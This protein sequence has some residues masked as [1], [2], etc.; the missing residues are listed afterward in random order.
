MLL[1]MICQ[2]KKR[3]KAIFMFCEA[4]IF[5][6]NK[7]RIKFQDLLEYILDNLGSN[8]QINRS[9]NMPTPFLLN[10]SIVLILVGV[11][12]KGKLKMAL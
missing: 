8:I 3:N 9:E 1:I 5:A 12:R 4:E 10:Y 6:L 2:Y 11:S 7:G